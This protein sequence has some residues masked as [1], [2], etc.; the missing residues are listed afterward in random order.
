MTYIKNRTVFGKGREFQ[1]EWK[2]YIIENY[3]VC[4]I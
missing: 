3:L 4:L 1:E 2:S